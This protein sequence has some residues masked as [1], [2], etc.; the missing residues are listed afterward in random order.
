[1]YQVYIDSRSSM[2]SHYREFSLTVAEPNTQPTACHTSCIQAPSSPVSCQLR[3]SHHTCLGGR[4]DARTPR[5]LIHAYGTHL[6]PQCSAPRSRRSVRA[7]HIGF[8]LPLASHLKKTR[9]GNRQGKKPQPLAR[10]RQS[11]RRIKRCPRSSLCSFVV[12]P[13]FRASTPGTLDPSPFGGNRH[14]SFLFHKKMIP[15]FPCK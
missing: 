6:S 9:I 14:V 8:A 5:L 13:R 15:I 2:T 11:G 3:T 7:S 1:M 4:R 10:A 12:P